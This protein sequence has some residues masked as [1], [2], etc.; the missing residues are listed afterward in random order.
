MSD[1]TWRLLFV[2]NRYAGPVPWPRREPRSIARLDEELRAATAS[3]RPAPAPRLNGSPDP[4]RR[5][6]RR[7]RHDNGPP[8]REPQATDERAA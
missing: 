6:S 3:P 2:C 4:P 8:A 5:P 7:Q 1:M